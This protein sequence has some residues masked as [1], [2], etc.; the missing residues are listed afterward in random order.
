[1]KKATEIKKHYFEVLANAQPF[2]WGLPMEIEQNLKKFNEQFDK[3]VEKGLA[4][5]CERYFWKDMVQ[6]AKTLAWVLNRDI[7]K[8]CKKLY[9]ESHKE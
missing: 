3:L 9:Q 7:Y 1:M 4:A 6:E 8:D 5:E 2:M